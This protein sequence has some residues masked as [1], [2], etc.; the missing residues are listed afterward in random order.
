LFA[1]EEIVGMEST[2]D[3]DPAWTFVTNH[4]HVL[5]ILA[6]NPQARVRDIA[7]IIGSTERTAQKII[8]DLVQDGFVERVREGR[9]N[10]YVIVPGRHL[11]HPGRSTVPVQGLI[12]LFASSVAAPDVRPRPVDVGQESPMA[13]SE[14]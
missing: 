14:G 4:A 13:S 6:A 1:V 3:R 2:A 7:A 11:R 8:N 9:R 12:D 5:V 10:R